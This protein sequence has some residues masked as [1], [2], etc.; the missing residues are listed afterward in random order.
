MLEQRCILPE[1]AELGVA[2]GWVDATTVDGVA[3]SVDEDGEKAAAGSRVDD[4]IDETVFDVAGLVG[5]DVIVDIRLAG[6]VVV[7]AVAGGVTATKICLQPRGWPK[8]IATAIGDGTNLKVGAPVRRESGGG[9]RRKKF[10]W[11]SPFTFLALK[12]QLVVLMSA[13]VMVSTVWSVFVCCSSNYGAPRAQPFVKVGNTCPRALWSRR[14][15]P[16]PIVL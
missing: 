4:M 9:H 2:V 16:L 6:V 14:H 8:K 13:F 1:R 7:V 10:F 12:V 15:W 5:G 11:S 3:V